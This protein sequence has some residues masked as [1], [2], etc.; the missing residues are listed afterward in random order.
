MGGVVEASGDAGVGFR[1]I[2]REDFTL[3]QLTQ[4]AKDS[5]GDINISMYICLLL[6]IIIEVLN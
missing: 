5:L 1:V 6:L 2:F 4:N 3:P